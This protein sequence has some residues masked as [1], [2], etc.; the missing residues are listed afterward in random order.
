MKKNITI[1]IITILTLLLGYSSSLLG[2]KLLKNQNERVKTLN[3]QRK[4]FEEKWESY[5]VKNGFY[6]ENGKKTKAPGWKIFK[7]AEYFWEQRIYLNSGEFP[8]T[9]AVDEYEKAKK[10]LDKTTYTESWSNLGTNS[11]AGGYAGIGR[12]NCIAFHPTDVNTF[13]V[14]S[15]SGGIWK[16]TTGG[17]SWTILNSSLSVLGV[18]AIVVDPT[19]T[20][21][22][23]IATGDRDGGSMASLGGGQVADNASIGIYKTTNGGT[24]WSP[25][26]LTYTTSQKVKVFDLIMDP[27]NSQTLLAST[28]YASSGTSSNG[29]IYR[30]TNGGTSWTQSP[31]SYR[32]WR[33]AYKPGSSS[34]VYGTEAFGGE[35]YFQ[36][37]IDGGANWSDFTF[38]SGTDASRTELA[39]SAGESNT[40]Y[41]LVAN[42]AGGVNGI[43]KSTDSGLNFT[44]VNTNSATQPGMLGYNTDGSGGATGQGTY[45]LCI[46]VD[47]ATPGTIFIGGITTWKSTDFGV[48]WAAANNWTSNTAGVP[49]VHADKH[50][51]AYQPV[52][53]NLFEG[54]DGGIYKTTNSGASWTDLSNGLVISQIYRLGVSQTNASKVI[55]GL[56]DNGAKL[57]N[58]GAWTDVS[59]GDGMECIIDYSNANY[60]Y[61][62]YTEGKIYLSTDGATFSNVAITANIP[63]GQPTGAWVTPYVIH[64]STPSTIFVAYDK[65]WKTTDRGVSTGN[66]S[67]A[68]Q[69]LSSS[70]LLRSLAI[71]PSDGNVIY[72][73][74]QTNMWKTTDG[75]ATNW[76]PITLPT[77]SNSIT[78]IAVHATNPDIVW[79]TVGG[80]TTGQK[81]YQSSNGGASWTN[82]SGA[83]PNLPIMSIVHYKKATDRNVLFVSTDLGVYVSEQ[84]LPG[85]PPPPTSLQKVNVSDWAQY[86]TGLPNVVVAELEIFYA[87]SGPD[88]LR[89]ATFGRGLWETNVDAALPVELTSFS[90]NS[91]EGSKVSLNWETATEVNNYGFEIERQSVTD[92]DKTSKLSE[93]CWT[94]IGFING[95][96]N[97]N[98]PKQYSF[99]D[100]LISG[101]SNFAYRLKQIDIDGKFEYSDVVEV[102]VLPTNFVLQ[103]N[104]PNPFNP[105]TKISYSVPSTNLITLSVFDVLGREVVK[106]VNEIQEQGVYE[107]G[108]DA[109]QF[110]SGIYFYSL[111][112]GEFTMTKKMMLLK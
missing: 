109:S 98:S 68:S 17:N 22:I 75:G 86:N 76:T 26:G 103:Q 15:P 82:I 48:T 69:T 4:E 12:I 44:K 3:E 63:G 77:L 16:T 60:M 34:I 106:L 100:E 104:Y 37:S 20:D 30:T 74:D 54:N 97:S 8:K 96:G 50:A 80:F 70:N 99:V 18:S 66:W 45:D 9:T 81:V 102:K 43:Y 13:W 92:L 47:P 59:G 53:G 46:A 62:T 10:R 40:V 31:G 2:Q 72:T 5:D 67:T 14:G 27:N 29:A 52:S 28:S 36:R 38:G 56:Q 95:S 24:S 42:A 73:A 101:G 49:T 35:Q 78:Y 32:A 89:A 65:V 93:D 23:Y 51:L 21:I 71:A 83:L 58:T 105:E 88:K 94:S 6:I 84:A 61:A 107:A 7:R 39:V 108:F 85:S 64:P 11:S 55:T 110:P 90:A 41:L 33:L 25:T 112:A 1:L 57:Y 79:F 87:A 19:N 91:I 111:Q